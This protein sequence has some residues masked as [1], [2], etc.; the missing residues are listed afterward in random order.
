MDGY[1]LKQADIERLEGLEK[2]HFLNPEAER[3]NKS[4][5]DLTGLTD[6]G[7][8]LIEVPPEKWTTERHVHYF[9]DEC[10]YVLAGKATAH[11]G[12]DTVE[13][14]AGDFIGYRAGGESHT[15]HNTGSE[16]LRCLV[17]G[18]RLPH[19]V[20]DY[21]GLGKRLFRNAGQPWQIA[22][23]TDLAEPDAGRK[24]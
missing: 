20:T 9:E 22:D 8:H 1:V 6:F 15:I 24:V 23:A 7:V 4:L 17:V 18:S 11:I 10:V 3:V 14:R 21:P 2:R 13:I 12:D 19:D 16:T 5:G